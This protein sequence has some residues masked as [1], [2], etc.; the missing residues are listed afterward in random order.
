MCAVPQLVSAPLNPM[1]FWIYLIKIYANFS[2]LAFVFDTN[3]KLHI[4]HF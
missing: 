4:I 3:L 2:C 1:M